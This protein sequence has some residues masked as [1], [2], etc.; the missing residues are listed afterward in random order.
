MNKGLIK[1]TDRLYRTRWKEISVIF[2]DFR[3]FHIEFRPWEND[4]WYLYGY[5]DFFDELKEWENIPEYNLVFKDYS[6]KS[7]IYE[8][9]RARYQHVPGSYETDT[10]K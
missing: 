2:K 1:I 5:S 3:P 6:I 8:F 7:G 9:K 10:I 4:I